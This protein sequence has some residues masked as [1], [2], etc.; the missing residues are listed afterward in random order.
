MPGTSRHHWGTD[1]DLNALEDE[2]FLEG[3]GKRIY[4]W[5]R[6]NAGRFGFCQTYT[7]KDADRPNGYEEEKWHWT[8][9]PVSKLILQ[10]ARL[11]MT[12]QNLNGFEGS[13][14]ASEIEVLE[15]YV[16]GIHPDCV[17]L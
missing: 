3:E 2:W 14:T 16:L 7:V 4:D 13:E 12:N 17:G 1:I 5:L 15:N 8:Y 10:S 11:V 9:A 6:N